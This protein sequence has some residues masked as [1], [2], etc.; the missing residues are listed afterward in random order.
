AADLIPVAAVAAV[1]AVQA[2]L[3]QV[4]GK[5]HDAVWNRRTA[6]EFAGA[7]GAGFIARYAAGFGIRQLSKLIPVYGQTAGAA[8]AAATS[9]ATTYALGKAANHFLTER[10]RGKTDTAAVRKVW[11]EALREAFDL[12]KVRGLAKDQPANDEGQ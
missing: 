6:W 1:P 2:R 4:L 12:A 8:A 11:A 5:R 9:F 3:L 10:N 7:L